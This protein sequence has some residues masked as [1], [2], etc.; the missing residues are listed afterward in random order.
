MTAVQWTA[1]KPDGTTNFANPAGAGITF[2]RRGS[3]TQWKVDNARW[4]STQADHCNDT[5]TYHIT[6]SFT[7]TGTNGSLNCSIDSGSY[8]TLT[9]DAGSNAISGDAVTDRYWTGVMDISVNQ[10][11][12][13]R[14]YGTV[15]QGTWDRDVQA[16][17]VRPI[18]CPQDSQYYD[19]TEAEEVF[20]VGQFDGTG[21]TIL[22]DLW[23]PDRVMNNLWA[24]QPYWGATQTAAHVATALAIANAR[25]TEEERSDQELEARRCQV[26]S[27]AKS[28][29]GASYRSTLECCYP[30]CQ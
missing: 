1:T 21:S 22:N 8:A 6:A 29:A 24:G 9:V 16:H 2:S 20:H 10:E 17:V 3:I 18:H 15:S 13:N 19:M 5:S 11:D 14:W 7:I 12:P 23:D 26:E 27:E 30:E 4:F 25:Y 28:A